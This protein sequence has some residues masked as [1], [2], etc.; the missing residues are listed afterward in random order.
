MTNY[1]DKFEALLVQLN[2][3]ER[4]EVLEFYREY[5]LDA[6]IQDYDDCVAELGTP[7]QLARKILADY[8]IRFN[9][10]LTAEST[11]RQKGQA[12]VRAIWWVVLAL[13]STPITIPALIVILAVLFALA[14]VVFAIAVA[15]F[16]IILAAT[17][18]ALSAIT[19]GV[20][21]FTQSLWTA[22]FYIGGGLTI[23]GIELLIFPLVMWFINLIIQGVSTIVQRL[24]HRFVKRNRAERGGRHHEKNR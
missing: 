1:L 12:G 23:I 21:V 22:I 19:A 13:L 16:A 7:K 11:K 24:Y 10:N 14:A 4:D 6:N 15:V 20:G 17:L 2:D 8:S 9:E 5:L 18:L 3:D